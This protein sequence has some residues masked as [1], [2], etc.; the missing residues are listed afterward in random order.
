MFWINIIRPLLESCI[1]QLPPAPTSYEKRF[2]HPRLVHFSLFA[3]RWKQGVLI[4]TSLYFYA[5]KEGNFTHLRILCIGTKRVVIM[6]ST[7]QSVIIVKQALS[8]MR[9]LPYF[10]EFPPY[11][12]ITSPPQFPN[13]QNGAYDSTY[14][15]DSW[16]NDKIICLMNLAESSKGWERLSHLPKTYIAYKWLMSTLNWTDST[17]SPG[18]PVLCRLQGLAAVPHY[19]WSAMPEKTWTS[20]PE[21]CEE[22]ADGHMPSLPFDPHSQTITMSQHRKHLGHHA[23]FYTWG[24][25]G[26]EQEVLPQGHSAIPCSLE[27]VLP[28]S[29]P[30]PNTLLLTLPPFE[31]PLGKDLSPLFFLAQSSDSL[32]T[33]T[34]FS[35][36]FSPL[37]VQAGSPSSGS[38][39]LLW[40]FKLQSGRQTFICAKSSTLIL[41]LKFQNCTHTVDVGYMWL[42]NVKKN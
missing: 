30:Q 35:S 34:W 18:T 15:K 16:R 31:T 26:P 28:P 3:D 19:P 38:G 36:F 6:I 23:A 41:S 29:D 42:L 8:E 20:H 9:S 21:D 32:E 22:P 7:Y 5:A 25:W 24:N 40:I 17:P 39:Y 37:W 12:E 2:G 11:C 33:S 13:L 1:R 27:L 14:L 10:S 4:S